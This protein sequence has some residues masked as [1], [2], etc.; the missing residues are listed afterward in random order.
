[1]SRDLRSFVYI[2]AIAAV[3]VAASGLAASWWPLPLETRSLL[4]MPV[5]G[6]FIAL[7]GRFPIEISRQAPASLSTMPM[8]MTVLLLHPLDAALVTAMGWFISET[9]LGAPAK[10]V[11]FNVTANVAACVFAGVVFFSLMPSDGELALTGGYMLAAGAAGITLHATN[12]LLVVGMVTLRKGLAFWRSWSEAYV[13]EV[14]QE[15][16]LVTLGLIA[17]VLYIQAPWSV[18]LVIIPSILAYYGFRRNVSEAAEKARMAEELEERLDELKELQ[19]QLI[20][21]AKL[22]SVGTLAAGIAHEI[23][24]PVFAITGRSELLLKDPERHL[25]GEKALYY[26]KTIYEMGERISQIVRQLLDYSRSSEEREEVHMVDTMEAA[27]ALLGERLEPPQAAL[28]RE[29]AN[30]PPVMAVGSQLQ[31]VFVNLL[32]NALDA[33]GERSVITVGCRSVGD[34]VECYVRDAGTGIPE[35]LLNNCVRAFLYHERSREG[36]RSRFVRMSQDRGGARRRNFHR[37]GQR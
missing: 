4:L 28:V 21:S 17:A 25:R 1:M 10:A 20:Q 36:D 18:V 35:E 33:S 26:V 6:A 30:V 3:V 16:G 23:N 32:S 14:V 11:A 37:R 13:F 31:Q 19:A 12:V 27:L 2:S 7:A 5:L 9:A 29:Y 24:N 8:F 15:S 34:E 22:A